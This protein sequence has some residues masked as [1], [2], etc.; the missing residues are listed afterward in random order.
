MLRSIQIIMFIL[1]GWCSFSFADQTDFKQNTQYK[2]CAAILTNIESNA[3]AKDRVL[4]HWAQNN[5][6]I[7]YQDNLDFQRDAK[8]P[9]NNLGDGFF[10]SVTE[11]WLAWFCFEFDLDTQATTP[12]FSTVMINSL[13]IIAGLS[14]SYPDWRQTLVSTDFIEWLQTQSVLYI[15]CGNNPGCYGLV[16][17]LHNLLDRYYLRTMVEVIIP[18]EVPEKLP[19]FP[20][21]Y[22]L[23]SDDLAD[24]A[25]WTETL[26]ELDALVGKQY[27]N[28]MALYND[29][30][31]LLKQLTD[32]YEGNLIQLIKKQSVAATKDK[33]AEVVYLITEA[34]FKAMSQR[35]NIAILSE[36]QLAVL[37]KIENLVFAQQYLVDVALKMAGLEQLGE[38]AQALI[39]H[40]AEKRG[41]AS[42]QNI[43]VLE[44]QA[45]PDCG[46]AENF[47]PETGHASVFYGFSPY[48]FTP[49][50]SGI[51]DFSK[52][53]RIGYFS[54][55][56]KPD[57]SG[58]NHL[59]TPLNWRAER[60]YSQF[61]D[62]AHSHRVK[63]DLVISNR[64]AAL[65]KKAHP[66]NYDYGELLIE[67]IDR[68]IKTPLLEYPVNV[69]KPALSFGMSPTRTMADGVT[70]NFDLQQMTD[71]KK[72]D[73]F[74]TFI[75]LLKSQL[76]GEAS[77][78]GQVINTSSN[79]YFLN[80]MVPVAQL[81]A[82]EGKGS[83]FYTMENLIA[84]EPYVD[85]FIMVFEDL[86]A[87]VTNATGKTDNTAPETASTKTTEPQD[88]DTV[89]MMKKLRNL[90]GKKQYITS[91]DKLYS[92][93][94]PMLTTINDAD[95]QQDLT[96]T[97]EYTSWSFLGAAYW[98]LPLTAQAQ[99][100][101]DNTYFA[102]TSSHTDDLLQ[103]IM[104]IAVQV[105]NTLCP[106]RWL[107]RVVL[108]LLVCVVLLGAI[109]SIWV[110]QLRA[111]FK[112]WTFMVLGAVAAVFVLLVF[113]CDPYWKEHQALILALFVLTLSAVVLALR[114][115]KNREAVLP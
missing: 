53:T 109:A 75:R 111:L 60:P 45:S 93:T 42:Q 31:P 89:V 63:V 76:Q 46:C 40:T 12:P 88:N 84:I 34:S 11:K 78:V 48:W 77:G 37:Q 30:R 17:E 58:N 79:R 49:E 87:T 103:P 5:L 114:V 2:Q 28:E 65:S 108:F 6:G 55:T 8:L 20:I 26:T 54:A 44:W 82:N 43:P 51:I 69:L 33:S 71:I 90:L 4:A 106:N 13:T 29:V 22:H 9:G 80:L 52:L 83:G 59:Q 56:L 105:C 39:I 107:L 41:Y 68:A 36:T 3:F 74:K 113:T 86:E 62:T 7:I 115:K 14:Q 1:W 50:Q 99:Q 64:R 92:K 91:A 70:L 110:Y 66:D 100:S 38:M 112:S 104:N 23:T 95:D 25:R 96:E 16:S 18:V 32:N 15:G 47:I 72:Q 10:G 27:T 102:I 98:T 35:L 21:Y 67:Q 97:L 101:L 57:I 19:L 94:V 24:F 85:L 73:E 81:L 61:V